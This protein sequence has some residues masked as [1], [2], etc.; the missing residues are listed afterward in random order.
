MIGWDFM[1]QANIPVPGLP[2]YYASV[3]SGRDGSP[4]RP[5]VT[6]VSHLIRLNGGLGEPALPNA[7]S[8]LSGSRSPNV[9]CIGC[10]SGQLANRSTDQLHCLFWSTEPL[11]LRAS[12]FG[13]LPPERRFHQLIRGGAGAEFRER[14]ADALVGVDGLE[15][16]RDERSQGIG[17]RRRRDGT[18]RR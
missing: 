7:R 2:L 12:S 18:R 1:S 8:I 13:L 16:K 5:F 14:G 10:I 9:L 17:S 15:S 11:S 6:R 4:S 3:A